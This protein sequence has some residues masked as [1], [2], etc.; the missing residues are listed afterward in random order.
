MKFKLLEDL[1]QFTRHKILD[2]SSQVSLIKNV[3]KFS[4]VHSN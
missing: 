4:F 1:F 2:V 3:S